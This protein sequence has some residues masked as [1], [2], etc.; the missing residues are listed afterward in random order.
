M[1][2]AKR[3]MPAAT[4]EDYCARISTDTKFAESAE[5]SR[6]ALEEEGESSGVLPTFIPAGEVAECVH[7][8]HEVYVKAALVSDSDII[9]LT[10]KS[11]KDLGLTPWASEWQGTN[12]VNFYIVS[13]A[14]LPAELQLSV[15]KVKLFQVTYVKN[16]KL[17]LTPMTQLSK[18]QP[19]DVL[20]HLATKYTQKRPTGMVQNIEALQSISD[21]K[22][23]ARILE[24]QRIERLKED[25]AAAESEALV[26]AGPVVQSAAMLEALEADEGPT[27]RK[28]TK[29]APKAA[30]KPTAAPA[31]ALV[32]P[33][34]LVD[35][36]STTTTTTG[37][38]SIAT[39]LEPSSRAS[40][41]GKS[42][43]SKN[44]KVAEM[45]EGMDEE[46][47]KVAQLHMEN[48]KDKKNASARSL[49]SLVVANFVDGNVDHGKG[50]TI[51]AV[52]RS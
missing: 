45:F 32:T 52:T 9:K 39:S 1:A 16:D 4:F 47:R 3:L 26:P 37:P 30:A 5:L 27:K 31:A 40:N 28:R 15:K 20:Q 11:A 21:L 14:D 17:W 13:L 35:C 23:L 33:L 24:A 48:S 12:V 6:Q 2:N 19:A 50:H 22:D 42:D 36:A 38:S 18:T 46:M 43:T 49:Q 44:K 29:T 25:G 51:A 10:G 41:A 8:G 7:F 34:A